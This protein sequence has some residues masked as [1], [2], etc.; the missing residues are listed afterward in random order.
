ML[1]NKFDTVVVHYDEIGLKGSNRGT[2]ENLLIDNIKTKLKNN[3]KEIKRE[4]GQITITISKDNLKNIEKI[5]DALTKIPGIAYFSFALKCN[6]DIESLKKETIDFVKNLKFSSFK[7]DTHRH[8]KEHKL[9][10]MEF[11]K[12][13]GEVVLNKYKKKVDLKNPDLNLKIE[14]SSKAAYISSKSI[15][16]VS[17]LPTN[18]KQKVVSMISGGFDS[19]VASYLMMK[20]GCSV[21]YV[22][23]QNKNQMKQAVIGKVVDLV[24]QLSKFQIKTTLYTI[25][26]EEIQKEIIMKSKAELRMI[27]YRRFMLKISSKIA[28]LNDAKFIVVGDSLSQVASQTIENLKATY[29]ASDIHVLS[30]LIGLNKRE[31]I[32][33]SKQIKTYDISKQPYGDCCSYFLPKHP[34][35]KASL[36]SL[37][38]I[39]SNFDIDSLI[40]SVIKKA[41]IDEIN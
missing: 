4:S 13:L 40:D 10:S 8:N 11:N 6:L 24:K 38:K 21:I 25:P 20:R 7:I 33:I 23:F 5:D 18:Q 3:F 27:I 2:F 30:P 22:H 14:I 37:K 12:I 26:F 9:N 31:I 1:N 28:Q 41:K 16:G 35:L 36:G 34:M 32:D 39:E 19:P 17:G 29:E 15:N